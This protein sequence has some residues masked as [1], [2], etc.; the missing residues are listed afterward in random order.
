MTITGAIKWSRA[1]SS[2]Q[3]HS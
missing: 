2:A 1:V 3:D